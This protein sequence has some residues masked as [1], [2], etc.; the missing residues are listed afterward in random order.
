MEC[1]VCME[2]NDNCVTTM[3]GHTFCTACI[4]HVASS[5][6]KCPLCRGLLMDEPIS[7]KVLNNTIQC[8]LPTVSKKKKKSFWKAYT[9]MRT[10]VSVGLADEENIGVEL[11]RQLII[12]AGEKARSYMKVQMVEAVVHRDAY[13][14]SPMK[15][16][17]LMFE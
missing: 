9:D 4:G 6:L 16:W 14:E 2:T 5:S 13:L 17:R 10:D 12:M 1:P 3:C 8:I 15:D 11:I 7:C